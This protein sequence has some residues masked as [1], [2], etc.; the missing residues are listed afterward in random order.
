MKKLVIAV[1]AIVVS[2]VLS[3]IASLLPALLLRW[4]ISSLGGP[5]IDFLVCWVAI[6]LVMWVFRR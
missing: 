2:F 5:E 1:F 4:M 3:G 6:T